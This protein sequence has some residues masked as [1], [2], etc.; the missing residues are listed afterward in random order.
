MAAPLALIPSPARPHADNRSGRS[1]TTLQERQKYLDSLPNGYIPSREELEAA[2]YFPYAPKS[3]L[4]PCGAGDRPEKEA[5]SDVGPDEVPKRSAGGN[6]RKRAGPDDSDAGDRDDDD[7]FAVEI[8][9]PKL[10]VGKWAMQHLMDE[11]LGG[12]ELEK[13]TR[14]PGRSGGRSKR[15]GSDSG[16]RPN[17]KTSSASSGGAKRSPG[18]P[19]SL[20][21][22]DEIEPGIQDSDI[23]SPPP[24]SSSPPSASRSPGFHPSPA[25]IENDAAVHKAQ[26][27]P[28]TPPDGLTDRSTN[29][30]YPAPLASPSASVDDA[31]PPTASTSA[32]DSANIEVTSPTCGTATMTVN[33][34]SSANPLAGPSHGGEDAP[35]LEMLPAQDDVETTTSATTADAPADA[36]PLTAPPLRRS[37]RKAGRPAQAATSAVSSPPPAQ[38]GPDKSA[39]T[40]KSSTRREKDAAQSAAGSSSAPPAAANP[41][42]TSAGSSAA[43]I[44][45]SS[46]SA[47]LA[48][49]PQQTKKPK[50]DTVK[51]FTTW[52]KSKEAVLALFN[53]GIVRPIYV[54][55]ASL[56]SKPSY[57][58]AL[59]GGRSFGFVMDAEISERRDIRF[60]FNQTTL[61]PEIA[62]SKEQEDCRPVRGT[63]NNPLK[64]YEHAGYDWTE[65][66]LDILGEAGQQNLKAY[67]FS[68]LNGL[69][70]FWPR[71]SLEWL[72]Q[73]VMDCWSSKEEVA[74]FKKAMTWQ[75]ARAGNIQLRPYAVRGK[76]YLRAKISVGSSEHEW[77]GWLLEGVKMDRPVFVEPAGSRDFQVVSEGHEGVLLSS[78]VGSRDAAQLA[79]WRR[80][81][82]RVSVR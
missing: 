12:L 11:K 8:P 14:E 78:L 73:S 26:N 42:S 4:Q 44:G 40:S 19:A 58:C 76:W 50:Q 53:E 32:S 15:Q 27:A 43:A 72:P 67:I 56:R 63:A 75:D 24:A 47:A 68:A 80:E 30:P 34:N 35:V 33:G 39:S 55:N 79:V 62:I 21:N 9:P 22:A 13:I 66:P 57:T 81:V 70:K 23:A 45:S 37:A 6:R 38:R 77:R 65:S 20:D 3:A 5:D 25:P 59:P 74:P 41:P 7:P 29:T 1:K 17:P 16:R 64:L 54:G 28:A 48:K 61:A 31:R 51:L 69:K 71:E 46:S 36:E 49:T 60:R 10:E 52:E 2:G 82:R 18:A